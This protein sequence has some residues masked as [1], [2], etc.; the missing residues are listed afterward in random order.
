MEMAGKK[1]TLWPGQLC[2]QVSRF[3]SQMEHMEEENSRFTVY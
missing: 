2:K 1:V 3:E